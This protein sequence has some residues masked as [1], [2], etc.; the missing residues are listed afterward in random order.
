[1]TLAMGYMGLPRQMADFLAA[2]NLS[3]A[4][5]II[6]LGLFYILVG[7]FLD[8]ISTIVLTHECSAAHIQAAGIRLPVVWRFSR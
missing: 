2:C 7:C 1:M 8:G 6:V 5:L 4:M 3:P